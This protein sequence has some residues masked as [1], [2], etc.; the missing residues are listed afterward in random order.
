MTIL[1]KCY[2]DNDTFVPEF[3][4]RKVLIEK[5]KSD[6]Q[7][8]DCEPI[9]NEVILES[10]KKINVVTCPLLPSIKSLLRDPHL[11]KEENLTFPN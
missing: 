7:M 11:M 5:L 9:T 10:G 2:I 1:S 6:T 3:T 4:R 8:Q